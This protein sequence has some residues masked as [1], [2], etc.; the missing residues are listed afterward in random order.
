MKIVNLEQFKRYPKGTVY[1]EECNPD[2]VRVKE[3]QLFG[4]IP[5][6]LYPG[7]GC[8][9]VD[10]DDF[11]VDYFTHDMFYIYDLN[12]IEEILKLLQESAEVLIN[13]IND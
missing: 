7:Y 12:D 13:G 8:H 1:A 9:V 11:R 5:L 10:D 3:S 6:A 4:S 2:V